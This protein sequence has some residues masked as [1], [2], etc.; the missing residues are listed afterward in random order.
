MRGRIRKGIAFALSAV[1]G[2]AT[3]ITTIPQLSVPVY[4]TGTGKV[5]T[6]IF[7]PEPTKTYTEAQNVVIS[8]TTDGADIYYTTDESRPSKEYGTKYT[9]A[10]SVSKTTTIKAIAVKDGMTDS[11][12]STAKYIIDAAPVPVTGVTVLPDEIELR[13]GASTKLTETVQPDNATNKKVNWSTD[14]DSVATVD[15]NGKVTAVDEGEAII[16]VTTVDGG[17]EATCKVTVKKDAPVIK[18]CKITFDPNGGK[19]K[20]DAQKVEKNKATKLKKNAFTRDGYSFREWNTKANGSGESYKDEASITPDGDMT[21]YAQWEEEG[22]KKIEGDGVTVEKSPKTMRIL[23]DSLSDELRQKVDEAIAAGEEVDYVFVSKDKDESA[24]GAA[25]IKSYAKDKGLTM[26][27]FFD[28]SLHVTVKGGDKLGDIIKTSGEVELE[29]SVPEKLRKADR[30]FY[31]FKNHE[32]DISEVGHGQ[33]DSV[34]ISTD[35]FSTYAIAYTDKK[36]VDSDDNDDN[37][38]DHEEHKPASWELNPN[39]KRQL[40]ISCKGLADGT[41]AGYQEQGEVAKAV[42][43]AAIPAGWTEVFEFN[44]LNKNRQPEV[45]LKKGTLTLFIPTEYQKAGRQFAI[46]ALEKG[47]RTIVLYDT[48]TNPRTVTVELNH[49]GYAFSLIY[50]D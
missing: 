2:V 23:N 32:G 35:S 34:P 41:C 42:I 30:T 25:E 12:V 20:M 40:V 39:E 14:K 47:G 10:I 29:V 8:C 16:T 43:K 5:A 45:S 26:G 28:L 46:I 11:D 24:P 1:L 4:A 50:K 36:T 37:D 44:L 38:D 19:G 7:T 3:C 21:L 15:G 27:K 49:T 48:D 9:S 18:E 31:V 6:P 22:S 13:P 33:G 17:H